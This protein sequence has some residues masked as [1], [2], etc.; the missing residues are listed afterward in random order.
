MLEAANGALDGLNKQAFM[1]EMVYIW[2]FP[3]WGENL[4][5]SSS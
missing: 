3:F 2:Q 4:L 1:T 5:F